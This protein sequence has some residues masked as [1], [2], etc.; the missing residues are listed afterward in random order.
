MIEYHDHSQPMKCKLHEVD[1]KKYCRKCAFLGKPRCTLI[2]KRATCG[3]CGAE[4]NHCTHK[5]GF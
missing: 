5:N 4:H 3:K 2:Q 1:L